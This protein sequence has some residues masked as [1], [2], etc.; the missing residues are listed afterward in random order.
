[1]TPGPVGDGFSRTHQPCSHA[2][3]GEVRTDA[4]GQ[5]PAQLVVAVKERHHV[6]A[7]NPD[8][9]PADGGDQYPTASGLPNS[10]QAPRGSF[11]PRRVA[12]LTK[13]RRYRAAITVSGITD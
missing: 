9:A 13:Q 2:L 7:N 11:R 4:Q 6:Q 1:M 12:K 5:H 3:P 10:G 8:Y